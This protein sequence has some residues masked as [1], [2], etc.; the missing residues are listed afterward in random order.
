MDINK[1]QFDL[2]SPERLLVSD[3]YDMVVAPGEEGDFGVLPGHSPMIANLRPGVIDIYENGVI[4]DRL[5]VAGGFA[6]VTGE[7]LTVLA[8]EAIPVHEISAEDAKARL[9]AGQQAYEEAD[10]DAARAEAEAQIAIADA[11]MAAI[12]KADGAGH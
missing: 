4:T 5:F 7:R 6:E 11:M 10:T 8:E 2:V 3:L 9:K 12:S 1:V